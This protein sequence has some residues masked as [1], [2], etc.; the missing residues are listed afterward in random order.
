LCVKNRLHSVKD[1]AKKGDCFLCF[2][3]PFV[4]SRLW[5]LSLNVVRHSGEDKDSADP[6]GAGGPVVRESHQCTAY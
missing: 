3:S 2:V 6:A 1:E 4:T 5:R